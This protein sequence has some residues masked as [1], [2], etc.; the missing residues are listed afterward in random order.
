MEELKK[1]Q[2]DMIFRSVP[3]VGEQ[4]EIDW[5]KELCPWSEFY[6]DA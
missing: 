2:M 5:V 4:G 1:I 3:S 6:G